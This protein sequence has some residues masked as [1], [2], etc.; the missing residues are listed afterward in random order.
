[1]SDPY[2]S[3]LIAEGETIVREASDA[4]S[5]KAETLTVS[6][7]QAD[8]WHKSAASFI[9]GREPLLVAQIPSFE[10]WQE[11]V[12]IHSALSKT[13]NLLKA[14]EAKAISGP[15]K[16]RGKAKQHSSPRSIPKS[17]EEMFL[18][19]LPSHPFLRAPLIGIV[20]VAALAILFWSLLPED[21]RKQLLDPYVSS[22]RQSFQPAVTGAGQSQPPTTLSI[23]CT[24][25]SLPVHGKHPDSLYSIYLHPDAIDNQLPIYFFGEG[26]DQ[27]S[28]PNSNARGAAYKCDLINDTSPIMAL[29]IA[30]GIDFGIEAGTRQYRTLKVDLPPLRDHKPFVFYVANCTGWAPHVSLPDR[31][32]VRFQGLPEERTVLIESSVHH[33]GNFG[34]YL[35]GTAQ[36]SMFCG[37]RP[38]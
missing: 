6:I 3:A 23:E 36:S 31:A 37:M 35:N 38:Q 8:R 13:L 30:F 7:E 19:L 15:A 18:G 5:N 24:P 29:S 32:I 28:W 9:S 20:S 4:L 33:L 27:T 16:Q 26:P 17:L 2:L 34:K 22:A 14:L 21:T 11:M 12:P 1:M 10:R 25:V